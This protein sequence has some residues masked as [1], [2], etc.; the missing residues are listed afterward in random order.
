MGEK[1]R[2]LTGV[3]RSPPHPA[4]TEI[5]VDDSFFSD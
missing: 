4:V 5:T 3:S 2:K 1:L